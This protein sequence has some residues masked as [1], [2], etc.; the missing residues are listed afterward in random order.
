M[1]DDV[2]RYILYDIVH[3]DMIFQLRCQNHTSKNKNTCFRNELNVQP[4]RVDHIM[5]FYWNSCLTFVVNKKTH[6]NERQDPT[7][8]SVS[9]TEKE[10]DESKG[11]SKIE[12]QKWLGVDALEPCNKYNCKNKS[13]QGSP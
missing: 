2:K 1:Q 11:H 6:S 13:D 10:A 7:C 12:L 9:F 4:D 8:T 3:G 5:A